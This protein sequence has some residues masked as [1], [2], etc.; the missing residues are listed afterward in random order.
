M[1]V[2]IAAL[3]CLCADVFEG[4]KRIYPG[5]EALNFAVHAAEFTGVDVM[6]L[7]AVGKDEYG[8]KILDTVGYRRIDISGLRVEKKG[9]TAWNM[10][11]LTPEGDRYYKEDSWH[12]GVLDKYK[13][14]KADL[15][16]LSFADCVFVTY[17]AVC[18]EEILE[19]KKEYG[20][21]LA[22]DF[23]VER[24]WEKLE[25]YCPFVD[26]YMISGS[27]ELLPV[28]EEWSKK[29]PG[30]FNMTLAEKGSVT[31]AN[32]Q[33]YRVEAA[34]PDEIVDSTGCGDSYHAAF[35]CSYLVDKDIMKAMKQASELAALT[36][37]HYGGF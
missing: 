18:F 30:L 17:T 21:K 22:V 11:Y 24:D 9:E 12:G 13:L 28:F 36:L 16:S 34:K 31:Y 25:T 20:F 23:D 33:E 14:S 5:G 15:K 3:P 1:N 26:F 29:Y 35:V 10:T 8:Q 4:Q 2:K 6:L 27:E 7:G 37:E 32:G 19:L